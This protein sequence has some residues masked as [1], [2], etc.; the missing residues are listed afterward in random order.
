M[1]LK[2]FVLTRDL[3]IEECP[4]FDILD[5]T[6]IKKGTTVYQFP[7]LYGCSDSGMT[8]SFEKSK[9]PYFEVPLDAIEVAISTDFSVN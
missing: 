8:V 2:K 4:W 6:E 7:D 9:Y 3:T 5:V 1:E